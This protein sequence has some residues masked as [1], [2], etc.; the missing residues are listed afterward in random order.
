MFFLTFKYYTLLS[1]CFKSC[2]NAEALIA[3]LTDLEINANGYREYTN[4]ESHE[5]IAEFGYVF[6]F[7]DSTLECSYGKTNLKTLIFEE[8]K[9]NN[10]VLVKY[11]KRNTNEKY[12]ETNITGAETLNNDLSQLRISVLKYI[13]ANTVLANN[14]E[15]KVLF[16]F[17]ILLTVCFIFVLLTTDFIK[18]MKRELSK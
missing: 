3:H 18:A 4:A 14:D 9:I 11:D 15:N 13:K 10:K 16:S 17:L 1:I 7:W 5:D 8:L 6:K 12:F 2:Y